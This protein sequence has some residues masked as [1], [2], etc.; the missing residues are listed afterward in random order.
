MQLKLKANYNEW[1][2]DY[3]PDCNDTPGVVGICLAAM[4]RWTFKNGA[5]VRFMYGGCGGSNNR[6]NSLEECKR[7]CRKFG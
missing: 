6:F 1:L 4:P 2:D 7:V 5:C 3:I